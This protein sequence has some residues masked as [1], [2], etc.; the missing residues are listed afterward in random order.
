MADTTICALATPRGQG[1]IAIV[2][3]S[4][5]EALGL[6][7]RVFRPAHAAR[8]FEPNRMMYGKAVAADG[9]VLDEVMAV[10][11]AAPFSY[12]REH[13][14]EI[15]CHGGEQSSRRVLRALMALGARP[16]APGE[17]TK[18]A[19]LNG[20]ISLTDAEAVMALIGA[21]SEAAAR[22][23]VRQL[24]GGVSGFVR[25]VRERILEQLTLIEASTDFPDEVEEEAAAEQVLSALREIVEELDR[26]ASPRTARLLR[27]GASVVLAGRPNVGKSSVMNALLEQERAIVTEIP[28]TTRDALTER[29]QLGGVLVELTDTAGQRETEDPV[30]KIGVARARAAME[31]ADVRVLVL[32]GSQP[33]QE[34]DER[35][36]AACAHQDIILINKCD[37]P[38]RAALAPSNMQVIETSARTG[39][40]IPALR[41][42][43]EARVTDGLESGA[44]TVERH[45]ALAGD[46]RAALERAAEAL[47]EGL[48]LDVAAID[49][50]EALSRLGEILG[51]DATEALIDEIFSR[52]CVGK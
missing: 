41:A 39:E 34:E 40:G 42:A 16:A 10:Y 23:S 49:I 50:R 48:P 14:A 17:F 2:R 24:Q 37:L 29:L 30:E 8:A 25:D 51:E 28:G 3:V 27:E 47:R 1:G 6:L 26:R 7:K 15:H 21:G 18:R 4:G 35:L 45:L 33:L 38:R 22:A 32:D 20:R 13:V 12:T 5:P 19:F 9:E 52:F 43:L 31:Q 36:L 11:M 46:A 44:M